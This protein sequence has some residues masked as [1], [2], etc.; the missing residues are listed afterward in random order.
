VAFNNSEVTIYSVPPSIRAPISYASELGIVKPSESSGQAYDAYVLS[1]FTVALNGG[2]SYKILNGISDLGIESV[3]N[4]VLL[5]YDPVPDE[6]DTSRLFDW[7]G[8]GGNLVVFN[9][10]SFGTFEDWFGLRAK[11]ILV[12]CDS[13]SGWSRW[14]ERGNI[15]IET[16]EKVEGNASLRLHFENTLSWQWSGWT[17]NITQTEGKPWD[18][19]EWDTIGIWIYTNGT[20]GPQW[21]L[22]LHDING[23]T[24]Q[25]GNPQFL[26]QWNG[27]EWVPSF[28]GWKRIL[29]PAKNY[30]GELDLTNVTRL[31]ISTGFQLPV[32]ILVDEIAAYRNITGNTYAANSIVDSQTIDLP[33]ITVPSLDIGGTTRVIAN[34]TLNGLPVAPFVMEKDSGAGKVSFANILPVNDFILSDAGKVDVYDTLDKLYQTLQ[35]IP[36]K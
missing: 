32:D 26:S 4:T 20:S 36:K 1:L 18:L 2:V 22:K 34:Y 11:R 16:T 23:K 6:E 14:A 15:S 8:R 12:S 29:I 9:T 30:Y 19:S 21:Y 25:F 17:Y 5:P 27:T 33:T 28:D 13:D 3:S 10:N 24:G 31:E 35:I 7:V